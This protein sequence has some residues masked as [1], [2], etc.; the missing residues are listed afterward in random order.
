VNAV[1]E[2]AVRGYDVLDMRR[3]RWRDADVAVLKL[4]RTGH[5]L[6][7]AKSSQ[8]CTHRGAFWIREIQGFVGQRVRVVPGL[9]YL[10][11]A[12]AWVQG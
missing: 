12:R 6:A 10:A 2:E 4:S 5:F 3:C 7:C 1:G 8:G 9:V 11:T